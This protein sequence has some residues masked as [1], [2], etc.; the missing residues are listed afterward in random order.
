[1]LSQSKHVAPYVPFD[2]LPRQALRT[3]FDRLRANGAGEL[4]LLPAVLPSKQ[5]DHHMSATTIG[6]IIGAAIDGMSGDDG[7]VDGAIIGAVTANVLKVALPVAATWA[8]GWLVL[9]GAGAAWDK[10]TGNDPS[11]AD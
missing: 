8:I 4:P 9:R 11:A 2:C 3:G 1:M 6:A 7:E 10:V 5:R